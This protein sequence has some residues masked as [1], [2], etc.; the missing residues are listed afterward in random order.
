VEE[1][2]LK[3]K[4]KELRIKNKLTQEQLAAV[5]K[6]DRSTIAKWETGE[7]MPRAAKLPE[8]AKAFKCSIDEIFEEDEKNKKAM[9]GGIRCERNFK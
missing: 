9:S 4:L 5:L 2:I 1:K 8:L 7:A 6:V 3:E